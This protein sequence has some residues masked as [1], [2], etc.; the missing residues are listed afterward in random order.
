MNDFNVKALLFVKYLLFI[1]HL[2]H[3]RTK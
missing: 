2:Q 1:F 3:K